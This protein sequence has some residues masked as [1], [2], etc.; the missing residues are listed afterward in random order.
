MD[1]VIGKRLTNSIN[2]AALKTA[3]EDAGFD[4]AG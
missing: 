3:I 2:E 4:V 1:T